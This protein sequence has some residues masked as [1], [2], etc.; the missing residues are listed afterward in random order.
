MVFNGSI[1][2][3]S[4]FLEVLAAAFFFTVLVSADDKSYSAKHVVT[5][6]IPTLARVSCLS[7]QMLCE[8]IV[9]SQL[10]LSA[11]YSVKCGSDSACKAV[12]VSGRLIV[13]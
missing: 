13:L 12:R 10:L 7:L 9:A 11:Y 2:E 8:K 3:V 5:L 6:L 4:C 1:I